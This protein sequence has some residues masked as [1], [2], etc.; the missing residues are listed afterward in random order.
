MITMTIDHIALA[1]VSTDSYL[2]IC[3]HTIGKITGPIMFFFIAEGY[4]YTG[5]LRKYLLRLSGFAAISQ[6]PYSVFMNHGKLLPF[7]GNVLFTLF[8]SL[9][10]IIVY[11]KIDKKM[12]KWL[13]IIAIVA[14]TYWFDW[15]FFGA[16]F[17]VGFHIFYGD[18]KK[19]T[20]CY[21]ILNVIKVIVT[22]FQHSGSVYYLLPVLISPLFVLLLLH[23]Y[24]GEKGGGKM[25][26]YAFYIFYPAHLCV[27]YLMTLIIR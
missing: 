5:N 8:L 22:Y 4:H 12:I 18:I 7:S 26:K 25:S 9:I 13:M 20:L 1:F 19:Q 11:E 6:I 2:A 10:C 27:I 21:L 23:L 3:M 16:M 24:N 17:A 15:C 14:V